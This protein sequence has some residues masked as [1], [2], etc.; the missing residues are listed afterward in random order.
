MN[1]KDFSGRIDKELEGLKL[2]AGAEQRVLDAVRRQSGRLKVFLEREI[3]IPVQS[4]AAGLL[5][6]ATVMVYAVV[7]V[8]RVSPEDVQKSRITV[9]E[10]GDGRQ[11]Y[12]IY[13]N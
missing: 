7:G 13:K 10:N 5:I 2:S 12:G 6:L 11:G 8:T 3:R 1:K 4:F 9:I